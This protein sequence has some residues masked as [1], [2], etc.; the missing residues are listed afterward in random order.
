MT[1]KILKRDQEAE[2]RKKQH[3]KIQSRTDFQNTMTSYE[4]IKK[5][6]EEQRREAEMKAREFMRQK[7][8]NKKGMEKQVLLTQDTHLREEKPIRAEK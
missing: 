7:L 1:Q 3:R 8:N 5:G 6:K 4:V 2:K